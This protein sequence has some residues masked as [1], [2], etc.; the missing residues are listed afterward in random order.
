MAVEARGY[1]H[2]FFVI[3]RA[4]DA[5]HVLN[6]DEPFGSA[7]DTYRQESQF[8]VAWSSLLLLSTT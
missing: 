8:L 7:H 3:L 4:R 5:L 2:D 1:C 6:Q